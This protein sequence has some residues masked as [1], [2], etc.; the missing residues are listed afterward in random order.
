MN[1]SQFLRSQL[2]TIDEN[3]D[4]THE[5]LS[6]LTTDTKYNVGVLLIM[7]DGNFNDQDVAYGEF[8]TSCTRKYIF[9]IIT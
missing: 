8:K 7:E 2:K 4:V 1:E 6:S 3:I 9:R 5:I